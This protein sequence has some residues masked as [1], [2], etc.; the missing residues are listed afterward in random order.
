[1][2]KYP[3]TFQ[4]V[5][6]L[7]EHL[8]PD[9]NHRHCIIKIF[10]ESIEYSEQ[11]EIQLVRLSYGKQ[12]ILYIGN[13]AVLKAGYDKKANDLVFW[14][15]IDNDKN[16]VLLD[17]SYWDIH[18][19]Y[20]LSS[21]LTYWQQTIKALHFLAIQKIA[22]K[23]IASP[24]NIAIPHHRAIIQYFNYALNITLPEPSHSDPQLAASEKIKSI[25][26]TIPKHKH[27]TD[28]LLQENFK[29]A[30][31]NPDQ[32]HT[33]LKIFA[34]AI[35]YI[36]SLEGGEGYWKVTYKILTFR[37]VLTI[38]N[39]HILSAE[40]MRKTPY[41]VIWISVDHKASQHLQEGKQW[42][43]DH[44]ATYEY[45]TNIDSRNGFYLS[46]DLGYWKNT[47]KPLHFTSINKAYEKYQGLPTSIQAN[48]HPEVIH[49]INQEL[50]TQLPEPNYQNFIS[51]GA[52][53]TI[54]VKPRKFLSKK[55]QEVSYER[56][57]E[58]FETTFPDKKRR[59]V[60][61]TIF[62]E[63]I[64]Y[65]NQ[66]EN[67]HRYWSV[68][69][70]NNPYHAHFH[71]GHNILINFNMYG[72]ERRGRLWLSIDSAM[73]EIIQLEDNDYWDWDKGSFYPYYPSIHAR[74]GYYLCPDLSYWYEVI[75]P[76][77]F[78]TIDNTHA[79]YTKGLHSNSRHKHDPKLVDYINDQLGLNLAQ[80]CYE[81][82]PAAVTN[83]IDE[84]DD[85]SYSEQPYKE[86]TVK[87]ISV[88]R[89]ERDGTA[90]Q[91]CI[92][93]YGAVCQACGM[94]FHKQYGDL[95][96]G[97]IHVHH[98]TPL[99]TIQE[100]YEVDP[101]KDLVPVCPNCHAMIH[102]IKDTTLSIDELKQRIQVNNETND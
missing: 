4:D 26:S 79:K 76:L 66:F 92:D 96:K 63:S 10:S 59:E 99:H 68:S 88:N 64:E 71:V 102:R 94:D 30:F 31:P 60:V 98:I 3:I 58:A 14:V 8:Y 46:H 65:I 50:S 16:Q 101:I 21:N 80:P 6:H 11:F 61:L 29:R 17:T 100:S 18:N 57:K 25:S 35:N 55:K 87:K 83:Y 74:N 77:Y 24:Q 40:Y 51:I 97:F 36:D 44:H 23:C 73:N 84:P 82:K 43:W 33:V 78:Q 48:H 90:R 47:I 2:T 15:N 42:Q 27:I 38:G 95:G 54:I 9:V 5:K 32:Q 81:G 45:Y 62:A 13:T 7:F 85:I 69:C 67:G 86:G 53:G 41:P 56:I 39:N 37:I 75:K 70:S 19:N 20:Y 52:D 22:K 28:E 34:D 93:H 12:V 91:A 1:M 72:E 89:Y 49:L